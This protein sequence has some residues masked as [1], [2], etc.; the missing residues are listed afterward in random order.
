MRTASVLTACVCS[1]RVG[2]DTCSERWDACSDARRVKLKFLQANTG[3]TDI[4]TSNLVSCKWN[5]KLF[6][7]LRV[8]SGRRKFRNS[9]RQIPLL[10]FGFLALQNQRIVCFSV[11][12]SQSPFAVVMHVLTLNGIGVIL[13][14]AV[15]PPL[16][17]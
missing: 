7:F 16:T 4:V 15:P 14:V 8:F 13:V 1:D 9:V 10:D 3:L 11:G 2:R 17:G 6:C 5:A 12:C